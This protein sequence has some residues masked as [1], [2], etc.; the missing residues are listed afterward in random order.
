MFRHDVGAIGIYDALYPSWHNKKA[1]RAQQ[2]YHDALRHH[3]FDL[4]LAYMRPQQLQV[5]GPLKTA[6]VQT[7]PALG[8]DPEILRTEL[9][10]RLKA[11]RALSS[12]RA[13]MSSWRSISALRRLVR[14][15]RADVGGRGFRPRR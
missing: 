4:R 11:Q 9:E 5:K 10:E 15:C 6:L 8:L 3:G 2:R 1:I 12:R 13:S 14:Q 7:A